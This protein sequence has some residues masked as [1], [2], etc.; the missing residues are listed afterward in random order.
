MCT[1]QEQVQIKVKHPNYYKNMDML[2]HTKRVW[3]A[4]AYFDPKKSTFKAKMNIFIPFMLIKVHFHVDPIFRLDP[5]LQCTE[6][7]FLNLL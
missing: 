5:T 4:L 2:W 6:I 7:I 1:V 3:C